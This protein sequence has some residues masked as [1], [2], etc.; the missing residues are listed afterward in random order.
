MREQCACMC[1][2]TVCVCVCRFEEAN[3][4]RLPKKRRGQ[5]SQQRGEASEILE[6]LELGG[7]PSSSSGRERVK[8]KRLLGGRRKL[9]RGQSHLSW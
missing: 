6:D 3:F 2:V 1:I 9:S 4:M 7:N 8:K 5:S